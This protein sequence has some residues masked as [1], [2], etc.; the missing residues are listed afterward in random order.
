VRVIRRENGVS[1]SH[2]LNLQPDME[3]KNNNP[4]FLKPS[5]IV[6]V[7]EKLSLF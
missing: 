5:D 7:P 6:Y 4:F 3:G 1:E 2:K